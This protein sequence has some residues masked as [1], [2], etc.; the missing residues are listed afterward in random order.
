[1]FR[2]AAHADKDLAEVYDGAAPEGQMGLADLK[3]VRCWLCGVPA[4]RTEA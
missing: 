3:R 1:M 2:R 4:C